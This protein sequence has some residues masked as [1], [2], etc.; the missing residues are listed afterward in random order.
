MVP[1]TGPERKKQ[2]IS[3]QPYDL[4]ISLQIYS[5]IFS[6]EIIHVHMESLECQIVTPYS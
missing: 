2:G 5:K 3:V 4:K 6:L 1:F